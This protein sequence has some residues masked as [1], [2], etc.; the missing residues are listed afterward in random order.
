[1]PASASA[2]AFP[3][4][5]RARRRARARQRARRGP[6]ATGAAGR[7]HR[8]EGPLPRGG[9]ARARHGRRLRDAPA[10]ARRLAQP[11]DRHRG[12]GDRLA[13][14][15]VDRLPDV[16]PEHARLVPRQLGQRRRARPLPGAR[17]RR[18][19][20]RR[21][22]PVQPDEDRVRHRAHAAQGQAG[23]GRLHRA[24]RAAL[25][26]QSRPRPCLRHHLRGGG[27]RARAPGDVRG[28][29]QRRGREHQALPGLPGAG[30]HGNVLGAI[31]R[32]LHRP[33]SRSSPIRSMAISRRSAPASS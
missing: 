20:A 11:R 32:R 10:G 14:L 18:E 15:P 24:R 5:G 8:C 3:V 29:L 27:G 21:H 25:G 1:M 23:G 17:R 7:R 2:L 16:V 9:D 30:R 6:H 31:P 13:V 26:L 28:R 12:V 33:T 4:A 22:R 19:P